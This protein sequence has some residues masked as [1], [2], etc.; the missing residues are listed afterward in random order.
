MKT[1]KGIYLDL[2]ESEYKLI[3]GGLEF[4]FSS[5]LYMQKFKKLV[6][7]FMNE[8]TTKLKIRY[9]VNINLDLFFAISLYKRIEKRGFRI[10]DRNIEKEIK[11]DVLFINKIIKE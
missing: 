5:E 6:V 10:Y 1:R 9:N 8:E 4:Y 7:N 11:S 3:L 2:K